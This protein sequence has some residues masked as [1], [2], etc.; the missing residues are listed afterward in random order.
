M[1]NKTHSIYLFVYHQNN[2]SEVKDKVKYTITYIPT[3]KWNE[4]L[5]LINGKYC[6]YNILLNTIISRVN[7]KYISVREL[8]AKSIY[9]YQNNITFKYQHR[10]KK[11][12]PNE[13]VFNEVQKAFNKIL[14]IGDFKR[15]DELTKYNII[16]K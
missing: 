7:W 13:K 12:Y 8:I 10:T 15:R 1:K 14:N 9:N 2:L 11:Y 6:G 3:K 16:I 4:Y 5:I